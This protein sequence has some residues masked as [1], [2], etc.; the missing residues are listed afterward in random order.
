[1]ADCGYL[2]LLADNYEDNVI[3]GAVYLIMSPK[4]LNREERDITHTTWKSI[5]PTIRNDLILKYGF[6]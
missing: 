4:K 6:A 1:M 5:P 2:A 3:A